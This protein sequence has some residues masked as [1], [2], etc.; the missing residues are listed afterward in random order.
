ML[1]WGVETGDDW[2]TQIAEDTLIA[3]FRHLID[4]APKAKVAVINQLGDFLHFDSLDAVTPTNRHLLD[5]DTRFRRVVEVAVR[6]L[7]AVVDMALETHQEVHVVIAEGNHD[8]AS[9]VWLQT[10]FAALYENEPRV[11]VNESAL[12]YYVYQHG[13][14]MLGF[15]HGHMKKNEGLPMYF[16]ATYATVWGNT[17]KRYIHVG[18]RHHVEEKEHP[19]VKVIQH[20][21]LA[22]RDAYAARG[23]WL[24]ERQAQAITYHVEFGEVARNTVTPEMLV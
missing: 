2:D 18:H 21:T 7:R 24:S 1:A 15:H 16:A 20:S 19:G 10:L 22:A 14:V 8:L 3:A 12:S 11:T 5:S 23:G 17:V 6:A 4:N 9:S 13:K